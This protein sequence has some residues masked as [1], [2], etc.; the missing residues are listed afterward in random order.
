MPKHSPQSHPRAELENQILEALRTAGGSCHR[1]ELRYAVRTWI[2]PAYFDEALEALAAQGL[3]GGELVS[4]AS[5]ADG[6]LT[7]RWDVLYYV[8]P[9]GQRKPSKLPKPP[10][11]DKLPRRPVPVGEQLD[12]RIVEALA[13]AGGQAERGKL[14]AALDYRVKIPQFDAAIARLRA[15]KR[16]KVEVVTRKGMGYSGWIVSRAT[17]YTLAS[18]R[19]T[20]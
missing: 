8:A 16:I 12:A 19:K 7:F 11:P 6:T 14:R 9:A 4:T 13:K 20:K 17:V 3:I 15:A 2:G 18:G 5:V 1:G 10:E